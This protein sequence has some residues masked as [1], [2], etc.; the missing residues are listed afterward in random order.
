ML[1]PTVC[2]KYP[3]PE[4][5]LYTREYAMDFWSGLSSDLRWCSQSSAQFVAGDWHFGCLPHVNQSLFCCGDELLE[6]REHAEQVLIYRKRALND[7]ADQMDSFGGEFGGACR[8]QEYLWLGFA[9]A[10][11]VAVGGLEV[12]RFAMQVGAAL[13]C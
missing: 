7:A 4:K 5:S 13:F 6:L 8:L 11:V 3:R 9:E 1:I 2:V 12:L 10:R